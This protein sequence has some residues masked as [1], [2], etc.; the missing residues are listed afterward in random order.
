MLSRAGID[1][2][3]HF[4]ER[5]NDVKRI[6]RDSKEW[7]KEKSAR[8]TTG[9]RRYIMPWRL[10]K[11]NFGKV[12]NKPRKAKKRVLIG[13]LPA[14]HVWSAKRM[15]MDRQN[16]FETVQA[17]RSCLKAPKANIRIAYKNCAVHDA[18][19]EK[20]CMIRGSA[21]DIKLLL[22]GLFD[23]SLEEFP[24]DLTGTKY[25]I[26][27]FKSFPSNPISPVRLLHESMTEIRICFHEAVSAPVKQA[28]TIAKQTDVP[29]V[30]LLHFGLKFLKNRDSFEGFYLSLACFL[31]WN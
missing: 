13:V 8:R 4:T 16:W 2:L 31:V 12:T 19:Y 1:A 15:K 11:V 26:H 6:A 30:L 14:S 23:D 28:L 22:T 3:A 20:W 10:R 29:K 18:S 17:Q 25:V 5:V 27:A 21:D 9:H 24:T 7:G